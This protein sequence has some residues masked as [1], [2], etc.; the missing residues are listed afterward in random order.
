MIQSLKKMEFTCDINILW[1]IITDNKNY[2][3]RTDVSKIEIVDDTHFIE[4]AENG[5]PTYFTIT[6]KEKCQKYQFDLNNKNMTGKW[7]GTFTL[8]EDGKVAIDMLEEV[9]VK[10]VLMKLL[11]KLY[12]KKQQNKYEQDLRRR[13]EQLK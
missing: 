11:A 6:S 12:L 7:T 10:S 3:W 2:T 13:V 5:F 1:D 9:D 8:L 4:Y